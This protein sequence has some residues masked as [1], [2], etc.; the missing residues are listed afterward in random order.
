MQIN[1][2]HNPIPGSLGGVVFNIEV[3][4]CALW[5]HCRDSAFSLSMNVT[6]SLDNKTLKEEGQSIMG[7]SQI[8]H[9]FVN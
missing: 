6:Q 2:L 7:R 5:T 9:C 3:Y 1:G 4:D 8:P